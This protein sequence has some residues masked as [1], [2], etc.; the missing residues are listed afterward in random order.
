M[1]IKPGFFNIF[2]KKYTFEMI[3]DYL[4]QIKNKKILSELILKSLK[5]IDE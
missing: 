4:I 2:C 3:S 1:A 5:K